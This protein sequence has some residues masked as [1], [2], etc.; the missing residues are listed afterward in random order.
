MDDAEIAYQKPTVANNRFWH[1][2][3]G[4]WE[5]LEVVTV[6]IKRLRNK[7]YL[8]AIAIAANRIR[9][10]RHLSLQGA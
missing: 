3:Y 5:S 4:K 9:D 8:G 2:T 10:E 7:V 1:A 6:V